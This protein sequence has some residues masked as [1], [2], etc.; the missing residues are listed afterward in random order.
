LSSL[1]ASRAVYMDLFQNGSFGIDAE[2]VENFAVSAATLRLYNETGTLVLSKVLDPAENLMSPSFDHARGARRGESRVRDGRHYLR[3]TIEC[4]DIGGNTNADECGWLCWY[5]E[6]DLPHI[7]QSMAVDNL[8]TIPKDSMNPGRV[9]STTSGLD[10]VYVAIVPTASWAA[11]AGATDDAKLQTLIQIPPR[12]R[13]SSARPSPR[14]RSPARSRE[15]P[16]GVRV[17]RVPHRE[18]RARLEVERRR[19][20][21]VG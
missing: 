5:P 7:I 6:A 19:V 12:V 21:L 11:V 15:P 4:V 10:A 9:P 20:R 8:L 1:D 14:G 18:P 13:R 3:I 17:G 16:R 2:V